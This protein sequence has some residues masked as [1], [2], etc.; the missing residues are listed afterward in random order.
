MTLWLI[1]CA[2][3]A[4]PVVDR[5]RIEADLQMLSGVS[6]IDDG[7]GPV[8]SRW[9]GHPDH[10]RAGDFLVRRLQSIDGLQVRTEVF[11][12]AGESGNRNL[13]ADLPGEDDSLPWVV[14]GAHWDSTGSA[15]AGW[16]GAVDPAPGADDDAS[17]VAVVL[18]LARLLSAVPRQSTVRFVLF[19]AEEQ[20]LLGSVVHAAGMA[21]EGRDVALMLALDPV[22]Y[23][24][25]GLNNLWVTFD[26]RWA[27]PGTDLETLSAA[28]DLVVT[29]LE[30][31]LI[32]GGNRS[33]HAS[34]WDQNYPALHLASFPQPPTYHTMDDSM[35][36]VDV[37]FTVRVAS[38]VLQYVETLVPVVPA[39]APANR[40]GCQHS[41]PPGA[42]LAIVMLLALR[43]F[44]RSAQFR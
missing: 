11:E 18:E 21:S 22:G 24:D 31:T 6:D 14:I 29:A 25:G 5:G 3:S 23:N 15:D 16:I 17:G 36:N 33:D 19:D 1:T 12:A 39:R 4:P 28:S 27:E 13:I 43:E 7:K 34:F 40:S 9:I 32:G 8:V 20:G 41:H 44:G 42:W 30:R 10:E 38:L 35:A 37:D 2:L 26:A